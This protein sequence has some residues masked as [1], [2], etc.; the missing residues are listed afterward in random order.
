[1]QRKLLPIGL[2][3]LA[4]ISLFGAIIQG[5]R[6]LA[7]RAD[8]ASYVAQ[9]RQIK[10]CVLISDATQ[11]LD[12]GSTGLYD[13]NVTPYVFYA[14]D[15]AND[16]KPAGFS[17]VNPLAP[18]V[19]FSMRR[20]TSGPRRRASS[21]IPSIELSVLSQSKQI[22]FNRR[23]LL[24][25]AALELRRELLD[26]AGRVDEALLAGVGGMRVHGHVAQ[27]DEI[28]LAVDRLLAARLHR[29]DGQKF[30]AGGDVEE[31]DRVECRMA[32]SFHVGNGLRLS[33]GA[34]CNA[35]RSC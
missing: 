17:F 10:A 18:S 31:A 11:D 14:M 15:T 25:R 33:P 21:S 7:A 29:R 2:A 26:A 20:N 3:G 12:A 32:F 22:S 4:C 9:P 34:L 13:S 27:D 19:I 35:G 1:M 28:L 16:L 5:A 23:S 6:H 24:L 30:F 8:V